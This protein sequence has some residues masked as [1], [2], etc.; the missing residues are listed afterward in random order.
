M[1]GVSV[2]IP[3]FQRAGWVGGAVET[4]LGQTYDD[5]EVIVVVDGSTDGTR[6]ALAPYEM[7]SRVTVLENSRNRGVADSR[8]Q[9]FAA[10]QGEFVCQL[11]DDDRWHREKVARQVERFESV[12]D[13]VGVVYTG[14][15]A[16]RDGDEITR[17]RPS[18]RGDLYPEIL[19]E[20][21]LSPHSSHMVR[22]AAFDAT[23]GFD[24]GLDAG[25]DWDLCIR[26]AR[27]FRFEYVDEPLTYVHRHGSN[28]TAE[29]ATAVEVR[30]DI[31][32]KYRQEIERHPGIEA[33]FDGLLR[34]D[35]ANAALAAG[36]RGEAVVETA[37]A[38]RVAPT[39]RT[40]RRAAV[41][42]LPLAA[43]QQLQRARDVLRGG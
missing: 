23:D 22:R 28:L 10:A 42:W 31:G 3:T 24:P 15:I 18:R 2:V 27:E 1:V 35:R 39:R 36:R 29:A 6:E 33:Q 21:G 43:T 20:F 5:L 32:E 8:N 17:L 16:Y 37:Q 4:A 7:D 14:G 26:I 12:A 34:I 40:V 19:V 11:D 25:V 30:R 13:D 38:L 41:V 9:G